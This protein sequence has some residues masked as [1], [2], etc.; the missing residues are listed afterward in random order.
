MD[1]LQEE[2]AIRE[3]YHIDSSFG[4]IRGR[5]VRDA[6]AKAHEAV[7]CGSKYFIRT[8]I[9]DFF[10]KIPKEKVLSKISELIPDPD[11]NNLLKE[12]TDV[13]LKNLHKLKHFAYLFPLHEIGVA[14]GCCLSPLLGNILLNEFDRQMNGRGITCLRYIDDFIILGPKMKHVE[15]AFS[16]AK[17]LLEKYGLEV[18]DPHIEKDKAEIGHIEKGFEF[19]GCKIVPGLI[20]PNKKSRDR[21]IQSIKDTLNESMRAMPDPVKLYSEKLSLA[22]TLANIDNI[23]AGWGN[24]Y[25]FCN[26][27]QVMNHLDLEV[28]K[29][30]TNYFSYYSKVRSRFKGEELL[31]HRR[32]LLGIHLLTESKHI[33]I[34]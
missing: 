3:Y 23:L 27:L 22:Q 19:L 25:S 6:I 8:D 20:T 14:Q 4:G 15:S 10:R 29:L 9:K 13:E 34:I 12:A 11:F 32:R 16:S 24:Q 2:D 26:N 18:Y 17:V 1:V 33:P 5:G 7:H 21:L 30:L 31:K 28:D